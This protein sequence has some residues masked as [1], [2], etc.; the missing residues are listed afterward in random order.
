M[1]LVVQKLNK[2][3]IS[4]LYSADA[5]NLVATTEMVIEALFRT[6]PLAI[7]MSEKIGGLREWAE[8]R[9]VAAH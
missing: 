8:G 2:P 4:A 3:L 7:V 1:N 5:K 9:T 6:Q